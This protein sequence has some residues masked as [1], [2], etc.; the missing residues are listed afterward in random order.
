MASL[1]FSPERKKNA[2]AAASARSGSR[3]NG[4]SPNTAGP[5]SP[6]GA[7]GSPPNMQLQRQAAAKAEL[8]ATL[9]KALQ[10]SLRTGNDANILKLLE[11]DNVDV[12]SRD[13]EGLTPLIMAAR[14]NRASTVKM[15]IA[16]K[17]D[18]NIKTRLGATAIIGAATH[19]HTSIVKLLLAANADRNISC[20]GMRPIDLARRQNKPDVVALLLSDGQPSWGSGLPR[21]R[22]DGT[23]SMSFHALD[24]ARHSGAA[25]EDRDKE[26]ELKMYRHRE[27]LMRLKDEK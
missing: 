16:H 15:L 23:T 14:D 26:F 19:G 17:A 12:D 27:R 8:S 6:G 20:N 9:M 4:K 3:T 21:Q 18:V 24:A 10:D 25:D 11:D 7:T 1:A 13:A 22:A 5:S 2:A